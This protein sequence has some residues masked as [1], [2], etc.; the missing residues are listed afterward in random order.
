[1]KWR[2]QDLILG[3]GAGGEST[4]FN[5]LSELAPGMGQELLLAAVRPAPPRN[6]L[7]PQ[8]PPQLRCVFSEHGTLLWAAWLTP[9][10][11][12]W[13]TLSCTLFES[14]LSDSR[15][16]GRDNPPLKAKHY[17][18]FLSCLPPFPGCFPPL[19]LPMLD[20]ELSPAGCKAWGPHSC[21]GSGV[22]SVRGHVSRVLT[23][24]NGVNRVWGARSS[25]STIPEGHNPG[26]LVHPG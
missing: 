11:G 23:T 7:H 8:P 12:R 2:P 22:G 17:F 10:L 1:M 3:R 18:R 19:A 26:A 15:F 13:G 25:P 21:G 6:L 24:N 9:L 14:P 20:A 4:G 5:E 16:G